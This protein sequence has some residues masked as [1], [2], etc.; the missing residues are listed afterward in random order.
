MQLFVGSEGTLGIITEV[1]VKL[2][3]APRFAATALIGFESIEDA[4]QAVGRALRAGRHPACLEILAEPLLT[5]MAD[6]LPPGFPPTG[7]AIIIEHD[8]S[9]ADSVEEELYGTV[10]AME[11]K[12][13]S[14]AQTERQ[15]ERLWEAR[16]GLGAALER[17]GLRF[18]G[19]DIAVPLSAIPELIRRIEA[20]GD[21]HGFTIA[22][23]GHAGDGNLH[24]LILFDDATKRLV[25][26]AAAAIFREAVALGGTVSAEHGLGRLK[27][28]FAALEISP[29]AVELMTA[30]KRTLDPAGLLNPG[31]VIPLAAPE[32]DFL[33]TM[34]GW[35]SAAGVVA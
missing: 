35:D 1:T 21:E 20:I 10:A 3:G 18:F 19:E 28:D 22:T 26:P 13:E 30:I 32:D 25:S 34:P 23:G 24:P 27:R 6:A 15:R 29:D 7:A 17:S 31:K 16:R 12:Y 5:V 8:G 14:I 33:V 2:I 4:A 11:G 9:Q